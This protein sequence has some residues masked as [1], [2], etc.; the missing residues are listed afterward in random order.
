MHAILIWPSEKT[1]Q[2]L[3]GTSLVFLYDK[4][5]HTYSTLVWKIISNQFAVISYKSRRAECA[6]NLHMTMIMKIMNLKL[7]QHATLC[8]CMFCANVHT[9]LGWGKQNMCARVYLCWKASPAASWSAALQMGKHR[10]CKSPSPEQS[11]TSQTCHLSTHKQTLSA[12]IITRVSTLH[13]TISHWKAHSFF[14]GDLFWLPL[15]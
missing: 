10:R 6:Y 12:E 3:G 9:H 15:F 13:F 8:V 11:D 1:L 7:T 14:Q 4:F 5:K 2:Y